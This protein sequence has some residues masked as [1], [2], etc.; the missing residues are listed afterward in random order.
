MEERQKA[1]LDHD[2]YI[3]LLMKNQNQVF[4]YI[5]ILVADYQDAEDIFQ[6]VAAIAWRK[7]VEYEPGSNF[8]AWLLSIARYRIMYYWQKKKNSIVH[9][10]D[11][12]V[13]AVEDHISSTLPISSN[14]YHYLEECIQKLSDDDAHLV[15]IRYSR[16]ITIK[17]LAKKLNRSVQ[18]LYSTM[19]RIHIALA[20]CIQRKRVIEGRP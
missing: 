15:R 20:E 1:I 19:S 3:R 8:T 6:D 13:K 7:L 18:G 10:S 16:K 17:A 2:E 11:A 4:T 14:D 5:Q 12:A 9:F